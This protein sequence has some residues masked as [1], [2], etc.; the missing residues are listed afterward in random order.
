MPRCRR[1]RSA[2]QKFLGATIALQSRR[3][4]LEDL[5]QRLLTFV[6][7][8][9]SAPAGHGDDGRSVPGGDPEGESGWCRT[10][11]H[12]GTSH[13]GAGSLPRRL[14]VGASVL[15]LL[16]PAEHR[17]RP[18]GFRSVFAA[19]P[20]GDEEEEE[21]EVGGQGTGDA[22]A[23]NASRASLVTRLCVRAHPDDGDG[24]DGGDGHTAAASLGN[25]GP[26]SPPSSSSL[27]LSEAG[28]AVLWALLRSLLA[29]RAAGSI[30]LS[31]LDAFRAGNDPPGTCPSRAIRG[32]RRGGSG[33]PSQRTF[34]DF[35]CPKAGWTFVAGGYNR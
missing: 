3:G 7:T 13:R 12:A 29:C 11:T 20:E 1:D 4:A 22:G 18:W 26:S 15:P 16:P 21:E 17:V 28:S 23:A 34:R 14:L 27:L 25:A 35:S 32:P 5:T 9:A 30:A 8:Q 33:N 31:E 6:Y 10:D 2:P 19:Y 24:S